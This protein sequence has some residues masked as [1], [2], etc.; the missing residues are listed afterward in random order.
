MHRVVSTF[1]L[2]SFDESKKVLSEGSE[3]DLINL[4]YELGFSKDHEIEIQECA[5]RPMVTKAVY[6]GARFFGRERID[7][8]WLNSEYCTRENKLELIGV[9]DTSFLKELLEM[10]KETNFT[11]MIV[12]HINGP[13]LKYD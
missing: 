8:E 5:H 6:N 11:A 3:E 7:D 1:D 12:S 13:G 4:L 9:K 10:S 2:L